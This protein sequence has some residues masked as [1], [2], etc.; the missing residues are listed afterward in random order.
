MN[1]RPLARRFL[2]QEARALLTRLDPVRPLALTMPMVPAAAVS[3]A[4]QAE[5]QHEY[6]R[7]A[8]QIIS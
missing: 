2:F 4:A 1:L 8:K 7:K 3:V 5:D 6:I